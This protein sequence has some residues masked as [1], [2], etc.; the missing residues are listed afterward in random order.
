MKNNITN[1]IISIF[2]FFSL[3]FVSKA[4]DFSRNKLVI[5]LGLSGYLENVGK[6]NLGFIAKCLNTSIAD[7][8]LLAAR[9]FPDPEISA[10]YTN[11]ADRTLGLGQT[12]GGDLSYQ[13]NLGNKRGASVSLAKTQ[14]ELTVLVLR[15]YF[16]N[17][18]A[19]AAIGYYQALRNSKLRELQRD[20]YN[21]E[22]RLADADSVRLIAGE[23]GRLDAMQTAM[24]AKITLGLVFESESELGNSLAA[25]S[26]F[27]GK[28]PGDTLY[29]PSDGFP[30]PGRNYSLTSLF[31]EARR[32]RSDAVESLMGVTSSEGCRD[33]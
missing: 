19:D 13:L 11:N 24:E 4:Q 27:M 25:M 16:Q 28:N 23:T 10:A 18:R 8:Q 17:L 1:R 7:A 33:A 31:D 26:V 9:T 3:V 20:I 29:L 32:N 21:E 22:K 2:F 12:Y 5:P 30:S 14:S 15:T 6:G